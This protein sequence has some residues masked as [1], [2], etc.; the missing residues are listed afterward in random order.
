MTVDH[1]CFF[2]SFI[3]GGGDKCLS[4][5]EGTPVICPRSHNHATFLQPVI[6]MHKFMFNNCSWCF[7]VMAQIS[8]ESSLPVREQVT[9]FFTEQISS[10]RSN[11]QPEILSIFSRLNR[12]LFTVIPFKQV[13]LYCESAFGRSEYAPVSD[14]FIFS[15]PAPQSADAES[16]GLGALVVKQHSRVRLIQ[17]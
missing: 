5:L 7:Y 4:W 2:S 8:P 13:I 12:T 16:P 17:N 9:A 3:A 14:A 11:F 6:S 15:A 1:L 10:L